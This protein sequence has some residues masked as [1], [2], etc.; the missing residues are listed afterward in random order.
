MQSEHGETVLSVENYVMYKCAR[1]IFLG[2]NE[3]EAVQLWNILLYCL[4]SEMNFNSY[5]FI[6]KSLLITAHE[7]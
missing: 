6:R 1:E 5:F 2:N 3:I 7:N 4:N